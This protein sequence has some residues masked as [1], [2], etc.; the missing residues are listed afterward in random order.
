ML[1][2]GHNLHP[3]FIISKDAR[4]GGTVLYS[5]LML[6]PRKSSLFPLT[7]FQGRNQG[8]S[9]SSETTRGVQLRSGAGGEC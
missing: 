7:Q 8:W 3:H 1:R 2:S 9:V 5:N 4:G 6:F